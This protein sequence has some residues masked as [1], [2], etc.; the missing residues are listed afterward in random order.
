MCEE[1]GERSVVVG[2][3][4]APVGGRGLVAPARRERGMVERGG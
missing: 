2:D 1:E 3:H 4:R